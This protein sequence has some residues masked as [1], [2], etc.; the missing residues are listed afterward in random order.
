M[1]AGKLR[2]LVLLQEKS[3]SRDAYGGEVVTWVDVANVWAEIDP[4]TMRER[5]ILRRQQGDAV[6]GL[7]VRAPL[8]V[9]LAKRFLFEGVGYGVIDID[10]TRKHL[11]ELLITAKAEAAAP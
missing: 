6:I 1:E 3:V 10:A 2:H 7:R 9:S 8:E 5:L 11:G 4:W